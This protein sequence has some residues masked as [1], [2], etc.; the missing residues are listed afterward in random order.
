MAPTDP[1]PDALI[2]YT[3]SYST[4]MLALVTCAAKKMTTKVP[5]ATWYEPSAIT[6]ELY[7]NLTQV[8]GTLD[9]DVLDLINDGDENTNPM[10]FVQT[11]IGA[12]KVK[13]TTDT[14]LTKIANTAGQTVAQ[15]LAAVSDAIDAA[16]VKA[17][18]Q[19]VNA[20]ISEY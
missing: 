19:A 10:A 18:Y 15:N 14:N 8:L 9:P 12:V 11:Q 13:F 6:I 5:V 2:E 20:E 17:K 4:D 3:D 7:S 16:L 1:R